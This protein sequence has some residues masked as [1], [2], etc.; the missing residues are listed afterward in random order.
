MFLIRVVGGTALA[1]RGMME[2][3]KN[4]AC[5]I[6]AVLWL[7]CGSALAQQTW[8]DHASLNARLQAVAAQAPDRMRILEV[9]ASLAGR[10]ILGLEIGE[11]LEPGP[12]PA[13]APGVLRRTWGQQPA[14]LLVSGLEADRW[15]GS[16]V[17][18]QMAEQWA[19]GE[20]SALRE[21]LQGGLIYI[22]PRVDVD[23]AERN[24]VA[25]PRRVA[26]GN[27]RRFDLDRDGRLD[28]A[29]APEDL[30]ADGVIVMMRRED[31]EGEWIADPDDPRLM[32]K[33]DAKKG[34][35]GRY[36]LYPEALDR[37]G[38]GA[39]G[40]DAFDGV[41]ISRNFPQGFKEHDP[42][43]GAFPTSEPSSRALADFVLA[44][45]NICMAVVYGAGDDLKDLPKPGKEE[46]PSTGRG[47]FRFFRNRKPVT[48]L[49]KA[50]LVIWEEARR[51]RKAAKAT[52]MKDHGSDGGGFADYLYFQ[53]GRPAFQV[54]LFQVEEKAPRKKAE[55]GEPAQKEEEAGKKGAAERDREPPDPVE[56]EIA[57]TRVNGFVAWA[58][59]DHPDLGAVEIGG[60][61]PGVLVNP[62]SPKVVATLVER[63]STF[64]KGLCGLWPRLEVADLEV[65][66]KAPGV[67]EIDLHVLSDGFL[68]TATRQGQVNRRG[69]PILIE[70]PWERERILQGNRRHRI[71]RLEGRVG[72]ETLH[73]LIRGKPGETL[74]V[75]VGAPG[76]HPITKEVVLP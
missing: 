22:I 36:K 46:K 11:K 14:I 9:G 75:H 16:E 31:P 62:S 24:L 76:L 54:N 37:D 27:G 3:M 40:E 70:F 5:G 13:K 39:F 69:D 50:D 73:W 55:S 59:F 74:R 68:P 61:K 28:P 15:V 2:P 57:S 63:E 48:R 56:A 8:S 21:M 66:P 58:S 35:R 7:L 51:L 19:R 10:S 67:Y 65:K 49:Q 42:T 25:R 34:E 72:R 29:E 6:L 12:V 71:D 32:R 20:P 38:D 26:K 17:L 33:A 4:N 1:S 45:P 52:F 30:N 18:L 47:G 43:A 60:W 53:W 41:E 64:L 23:G 44:H